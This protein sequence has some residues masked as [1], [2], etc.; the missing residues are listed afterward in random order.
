MTDVP[1]D[2][3]RCSEVRQ[4]VLGL[5]P[6]QPCRRSQAATRWPTLPG[7]TEGCTVVAMLG[8][9]DGADIHLTTAVKVAGTGIS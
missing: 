9:T 8:G 6:R 5:P 4:G 1:P 7:H 3:D 2:P